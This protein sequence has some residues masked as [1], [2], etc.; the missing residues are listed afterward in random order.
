VAG[1]KVWWGALGKEAALGSCG[2]KEAAM[3]EL[4]N[5]ERTLH[6]GASTVD[7]LGKRR[8]VCQLR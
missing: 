5:A 2:E 1:R 7:S 4:I 3:S 6:R 8:T